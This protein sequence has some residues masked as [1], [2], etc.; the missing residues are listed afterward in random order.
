[1]MNLAKKTALVTGGAKRIGRAIVRGLADRGMDIVIHYNRSDEA[2]REA[3]HEVEAKGRRAIAI[4]AD[5]G[6]GESASQL[7]AAAAKEAGPIDVLVN[8]ASVFNKSG[9]LDFPFE[10]LMREVE[11]NAFSPLAL[12]RAFAAQG[13]S[14][15]IINL[16]DSRMN[17]YDTT[18]TAYHLSK[19]MLYSMTRMLAL[20]LAPNIRVNGVAPGLI[21]P[22]A[23]ARESYLD[24]H[25][26]ENPL[27]RFGSV[28]GVAEAVRYLVAAEF[29]TGQVV[30]VDRRLAPFH[31][32]HPQPAE[33]R[34]IRPV[35]G[36][37]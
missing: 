26:T 18:H 17:S 4:Q 32:G 24:E 6:D 16:L 15:V 27:N 9:L 14:G 5:L 12:S 36:G 3:V 23:G 31:P 13:R 20:E 29:V 11:V 35:A 10:E 25:K 34:G 8:S 19:R 33:G 37:G 1:M 22:P 28:E 30:Y 21:L 7:I 2:A